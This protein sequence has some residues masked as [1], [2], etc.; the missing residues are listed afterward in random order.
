MFYQNKMIQ[1]TSWLYHCRIVS[2]KDMNVL[3][4]ALEEDEIMQMFSVEC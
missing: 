2:E 3:L 1:I 4:Q